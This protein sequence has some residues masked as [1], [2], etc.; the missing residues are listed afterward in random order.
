MGDTAAIDIGAVRKSVMDAGRALFAHELGRQTR[1]AEELAAIAGRLA[2]AAA[3]VQRLAVTT[4]ST[5]PCGP[6]H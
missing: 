2:A 6:S 4:R 1:T 3:M 5:D